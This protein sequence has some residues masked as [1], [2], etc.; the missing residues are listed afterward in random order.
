MVER[1]LGGEDDCDGH[2][3]RA[4]HERINDRER[5]QQRG[6]NQTD[7]RRDAARRVAQESDHDQHDDARRRADQ[8]ERAADQLCRRAGQCGERE[9][10]DPG[11]VVLRLLTLS[12][13]ALQSD[14]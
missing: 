13:F 2:A 5:A 8:Q 14:Q 7:L 10:A 6:A 12:A 9:R 1:R 11:R 4:R 3:D